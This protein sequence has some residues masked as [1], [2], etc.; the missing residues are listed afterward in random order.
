[1]IGEYNCPY[2]QYSGKICNKPCIRPEGCC[3]HW[4]KE[5]RPLCNKCG[6]KSTVSESGRCTD[7]IGGWYVQ[8]YINRLRAQVQNRK[9]RAEGHETG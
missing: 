6:E 2:K 7:C 9:S 5:E 1:M 4:K 8:Q 3:L